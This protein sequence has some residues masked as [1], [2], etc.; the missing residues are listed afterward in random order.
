MRENIGDAESKVIV[1]FTHYDFNLLST[2]LYYYS[3]DSERVCHP[4]VFLYPTVVVSVEI[5]NAVAFI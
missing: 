5:Y 2:C 1:I 3:V 4:L